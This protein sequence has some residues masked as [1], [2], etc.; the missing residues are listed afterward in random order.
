MNSEANLEKTPDSRVALVARWSDTGIRDDVW[1]PLRKFTSA[2]IALGRAGGSMPTRHRLA[3]QLAHA[4]ARDAVWSHFDAEALA[5]DIR[6]M[7]EEVIT[8]ESAATDRAEFLQRP[9]LGRRL[10][11]ES[12]IRLLHVIGQSSGLDLAIIVTDGLSALAVTTQA[13]PFLAELLDLLQGDSWSLAP[14]IVASNGRVALQDEIGEICRAKIS[15]ILI[16][17]R[18]GLGSADSMGAY[19]I[20]SPK[21]G[22]TDA[23][24]NC[25]SN[26]RQGGLPPIEAARKVRYLLHACRKM[27]ISGVQLKDDSGSPISALG[28][29]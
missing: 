24:R 25:V 23:D 28:A 7:G 29:V 27:S 21:T 15:L 19:F 10:A 2:R 12:R 14:L 8:V 13:L 18:P 4:R 22:K 3:F 1:A 17:E 20:Y 26:I 16:G 11:T 6:K 5:A 9:D